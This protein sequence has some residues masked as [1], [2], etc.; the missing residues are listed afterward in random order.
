MAIWTEIEDKIKNKLNRKRWMAYQDIFNLDDTNARIVLK[1]MCA[2][3]YV[4]DAGFDSDPLE[5]ARMA[6]ERN[7]VLRIFTLLKA[8]PEDIIDL[9]KED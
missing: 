8:K 7:V 3:H 2:A 9:A 4:F 5:L 1:D 6:G